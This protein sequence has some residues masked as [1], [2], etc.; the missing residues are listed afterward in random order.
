MAD[1]AEGPENR[2]RTG[3]TGLGVLLA[4]ASDLPTAI[5]RFA[6]Y[7]RALGFTAV[8]GRIEPDSGLSG[9]QTLSADAAALFADP[10]FVQAWP[11]E[12][13]AVDEGRA[14]PWTLESWPGR[15][16]TSA[17]DAMRRLGA[18]GLQAG[19]TLTDRRGWGRLLLLTGFCTA[20]RLEQLDD[21]ELDLFAAAAARLHLRL[22]ELAPKQANP[23]LTRRELEVLRLTAQG[24]TGEALGR[25]LGVTE[26]A[27]KFH[28][29]N[30]RRKLNVRKTA[31]AVAR[32][33]ELSGLDS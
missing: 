6:N 10:A 7:A 16:T 19:V 8:S 17:R 5:E 30:V 22:E 2:S 12:L 23:G 33:N 20:S 13:A 18:V 27:I 26:A 14:I 9:F 15:R 28:L 24:L 1:R 29:A 4:T 32:L 11:V 3:R 31:Q 25:R 21:I